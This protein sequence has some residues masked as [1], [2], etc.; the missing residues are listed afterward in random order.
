MWL[1]WRHRIEWPH[2]T[3]KLTRAKLPANVNNFTCGPHIKRPHTHFT[4]V[5]CSLPVETGKFTWVYAARTSHWII[6]LS[7]WQVMLSLF[8]YRG[9]TR[10]LGIFCHKFLPKLFKTKQFIAISTKIGLEKL[11]TP[12]YY[13]KLGNICPFKET[14]TKF[15]YFFEESKS[16][17]ATPWINL[18]AMRWFF[19]NIN[20]RCLVWAE[21][22]WVLIQRNTHF[23]MRIILRTIL[24]CLLVPGS[25]YFNPGMSPE[26]VR[27]EPWLVGLE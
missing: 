21:F 25:L 20:V 4:Y 2:D 17:W 15:I 26:R 8:L 1:A 10:D 19:N 6:L 11:Q 24:I 9:D 22:L 27:R 5:T 7:I 12:S 13:W 16:L 3:V 14:V 18:D 23:R